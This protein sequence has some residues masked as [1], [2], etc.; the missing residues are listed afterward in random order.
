MLRFAAKVRLNG[1]SS[2]CAHLKR[3]FSQ[4]P[5]EKE[6]SISKRKAF[7]QIQPNKK[8]LDKLDSLQLGFNSRRKVRV[9]IAKKFGSRNGAPQK[10][11]PQK[12]TVRRHLLNKPYPFKGLGRHL[13]N[14][15]YADEVAYTTPMATPEIAVIGRSN[16]GKSTLLNRIINFDDSFVQKQ[17]MSSKPGLT[18][19]ID[20]YGIGILKSERSKKKG[21]STDVAQSALE[22][23]DMKGKMD[24][25]DDEDAL[26]REVAANNYAVVL[27]DLPGY[28]FAFMKAAEKE[29]CQELCRQYLLQRGPALKRVLMLLDARHGFKLADRVY[30]RELL[31]LQ[32]EGVIK[33]TS[34]GNQGTGK[35]RKRVSWKLQVVL[36]KCDLV[37]RVELA[38][39]IKVVNDDITEA[40]PGFGNTLPVLA[41]A[42]QSDPSITNLQYEM[43]FIVTPPKLDD[44]GNHV[45]NPVTYANADA[46]VNRSDGDK[47]NEGESHSSKSRHT[48][49]IGVEEEEETESYQN[50]EKVDSESRRSI[51][52]RKVEADDGPDLV[53][54]TQ[55]DVDEE[56]D[57]YRNRGVKMTKKDQREEKQK[58]SLYKMRKME[59]WSES[60]MGIT[61]A[62]KRR[63]KKERKRE[64]M[65]LKA[66]KQEEDDRAT[67]REE[68]IVFSETDLVDVK[69]P[70]PEKDE[71]E[72]QDLEDASNY[73]KDTKR[74]M[75][76]AAQMLV[77]KYDDFIFNE[78][79]SEDILK[80]G[81]GYAGDKGRDKLVSKHDIRDKSEYDERD[82]LEDHED[83]EE[84]VGLGEY[85]VKV[86][87]NEAS[88]KRK[89]LSKARQRS[90]RFHIIKSQSSAR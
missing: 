66:A 5:A 88:P 38:R 42:S 60:M 72:F 53:L 11:I 7:K 32:K 44:K 8:V 2:S 41:V 55:E 76:A 49:K 14:Y 16:V 15:K 86:E 74:G 33:D 73:G 56:Y 18:Q 28:G 59:A 81:Q 29:R 39:R 1:S 84:N 9:A 10:H 57:T 4:A 50:T 85:E 90:K 47:E 78:S 13:Y 31:E 48:R 77:G 58:K 71:E 12:F 23:K 62:D 30:F 34:R 19:S 17:P 67:A 35:G 43:S 36:T 27:A 61:N 80:Y 87:F 20:F 46:P 75:K 6:V 22:K 65:A 37:D 79:K 63:E 40:L 51:R 89:Q 25:V 54:A 82:D 26:P 45:D 69:F 64:A 52:E 24:E 3:A 70:E 83:K 68:Q 21:K